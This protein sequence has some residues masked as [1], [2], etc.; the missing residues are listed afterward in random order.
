MLLTLALLML[1][2]LLLVVM[3]LALTL[4][5]LALLL[6]LFVLLLPSPPFLFRK[7]A[8][9]FVLIASEAA[10]ATIALSTSTTALKA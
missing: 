8:G 10:T 4:L 2:L 9:F 1:V 7:I 3:L 6:L 5:L